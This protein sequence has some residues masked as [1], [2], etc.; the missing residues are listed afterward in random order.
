MKNFKIALT[1]LISCALL[2]G[3]SQQHTP[4]LMNTSKPELV[5]ETHI[6]QIPI[7]KVD[8]MS[9]AILADRYTRYG[10]GELELTM[11]YDPRS[12]GYTAMKAVRDVKNAKN[13]LAKKGI[14]NVKADTLAVH[15]ED[16]VLMILY[17]SAT[18]QAPST[19]GTMPGL[20]SYAT[21]S[22]EGGI[23][24]YRMGCG[25]ESMLARQI[26]RPSDLEGVGGDAMGVSEGRRVVSVVETYNTLNDR[27]AAGEL[28][29][30]ATLE[31]D[32]LEA[33]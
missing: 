19:C 18:A 32:G 4:S 26:Y 3:C 28:D 22:V 1:A 24:D 27:Q 13:M 6:E 11:T 30:N 33:D 8:E 15:G 9:M 31:R 16:P 25:V 29:R 14:T 5:R 12:K 7:D 23:V 17:P 20:E 10:A 2:G 21:D